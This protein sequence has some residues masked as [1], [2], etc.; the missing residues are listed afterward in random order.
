[1]TKAFI[2]GSNTNSAG[3]MSISGGTTFAT[4]PGVSLS[5]AHGVSFGING[6]TITASVGAITETPFGIQAGTQSVSTGTVTFSNSNGI[7]FGMS[8]SNRITASYNPT[9]ISAAGASVSAG[10]VVFSNSNNFSFGMAGSTITGSASFSQSTGPSAISAAGSSVSS[11]TVVFSNS[12]NM[13]FGMNGNTITAT[14]TVAATAETPF[15]ISANTNSQSTGT[16]IFS[17]SNSMSFGLN[18]NGVLT[19]FFTA[20]KQILIPNGTNTG[21]QTN[22][23]QVTDTLQISNSNGYTFGLSGR[24]MTVMGDAIRAISAGTTNAIPAASANTVVFSN[25]NNMSFGANGATVTAS[26]A[27]GVSVSYFQDPS[28]FGSQVS[29]V[30]NGFISF[31]HVPVP[32]YINASALQHL[33][34]VSDHL[35]SAQYTISVGIYTMSGSTASLA[36]S[37]SRTW[38]I[39]TVGATQ[40]GLQYRSVSLG[41]TMTPGDYLFAVHVR[42]TANTAFNFMGMSQSSVFAGVDGFPT[43]Q[44]MHGFSNSS[45]TTA[46]PASFNVTNTNIVRGD[47]ALNQPGF[48]LLA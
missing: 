35:T 16:I 4:G 21:T 28:L 34:T 40:T 1:M 19:G 14:V 48:L 38:S 36:S 33:I 25:S 6:N 8:N 23:S 30:N 12:N 45:F 11:G 42:A 32:F 24:T 13:S 15:A 44:Y 41:A 17:A 10:T 5:N 46:M 22:T 27:G 39:S 18:T 3:I 37:G 31:Y 2:N 47:S 9:A 26:A 7:S 43:T 29:S 20:M